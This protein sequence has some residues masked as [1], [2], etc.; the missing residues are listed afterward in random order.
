LEACSAIPV[1]VQTGQRGQV[2]MTGRLG[3]M[4]SLMQASSLSSPSPKIPGMF[5]KEM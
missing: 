5:Y 1:V 4:H 2:Q 3:Q